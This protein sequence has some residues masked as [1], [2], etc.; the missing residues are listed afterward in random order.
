MH[1][2]IVASLLVLPV[3]AWAGRAA[4]APPRPPQ[5]TSDAA[6][7]I[8][9]TSGEVLFA[10]SAYVRRSPASTT[11]LL[12]ALVAVRAGGLGRIVE[13]SRQSAAVP[14]SSAHLRAADR[15]RLR[16]LLEGML[17]RSG[18]DA[19]HAVAT[20]VAGGESGFAARMNRT[21]LSIGARQTH[22]VNPHGLT[23]AHHYTSASDLA[24]I[25]V[26]ALSQPEVRRIVASQQLTLMPEGG[27][28][29]SIRNTNSLLGSY[30]GA[31]GAKT[32]T[33]NAAGKCLVAS[34]RRGEV[35]L[36]AVVL[37][38]GDRYGDARRLLD[39][40]FARDGGALVVPAGRVIGHL[41]DGR[42]LRLARDLAATEL[43]GQGVRLR[44]VRRPGAL[45]DGGIAGVA[46][47]V[48]GQDTVAA[49]PITAPPE[50][51]PWWLAPLRRLLPT[52]VDPSSLHS[53]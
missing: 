52:P 46:L 48:R 37:K 34:A 35:H 49:S 44:L 7:L 45:K 43:D 16:E 17:L 21:A 1:R 14:G 8:D 9:A 25:A 2:L 42:P 50:R 40:G 20:A 11:K 38:G 32:G 31:D 13:V 12:T 47:L 24:H 5:L 29:R 18:N 26:V 3:L 27:P 15:Y 30:L 36:I 10:Q 51:E 28:G 23:A 53:L 41:A 22:F 19:A 33:T 39:W 6:I 4:A